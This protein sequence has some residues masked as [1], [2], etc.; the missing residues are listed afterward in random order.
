MWGEHMYM[1][2]YSAKKTINMKTFRLK[3]NFDL[4]KVAKNLVLPGIGRIILADNEM[5]TSSDLMSNFFYPPD[6]VGTARAEAAFSYLSELNPA[7]KCNFEARKLEY[8]IESEQDYF[9]QFSLIVISRLKFDLCKKI[10]DFAFDHKIPII[11][12]K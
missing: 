5:V 12:V 3:L 10:R 8:L 1:R 9:R 2:S 11:Q 6:S 7:V 4:Y